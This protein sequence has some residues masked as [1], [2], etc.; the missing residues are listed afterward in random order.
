MRA[1]ARGGWRLVTAVAFGATAT[2]AVF[3]SRGAPADTALAS[4]S[5][6]ATPSATGSAAGPAGQPAGTGSPVTAV[7]PACTASGLRISVGPGARLT[8]DV[9][10]YAVEF[11]NVS[12][13]LCTLGGYPRVAAYRGD[14][15]QVGADAARDTSVAA[16]R[17]LLAPGQAAYASLDAV[18]PLPRCRPVPA[19]GLRVVVSPGQPAVRYIRPMTACTAPAA[20]GQ[21]YLHVRAI[22]AGTGIA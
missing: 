13:T 17:V 1:G 6:S 16:S 3:L 2:L 4:A 12:G 7:V 8:A 11:A 5:G 22:Q 15:V 20:G 18:R 9:T 21:G 19:S 14:G 10:R